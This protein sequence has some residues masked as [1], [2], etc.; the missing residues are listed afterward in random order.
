MPPIGSIWRLSNLSALR[1]ST[2]TRHRFK[3]NDSRI[4][5]KGSH[6]FVRIH[7]KSSYV[8]PGSHTSEVTPQ[9]WTYPTSRLP[10]EREALMAKN[11]HSGEVTAVPNPM[12]DTGF[13]PVSTLSVAASSSVSQVMH[14]V[15]LS[16]T[17]LPALPPVTMG[18]HSTE[19]PSYPTFLPKPSP[20]TPS[21]GSPSDP[22][23]QEIHPSQSTPSHKLSVPLIVLLAIGCSIL[24]F[25]LLSIIKCYFF[26]T[27]RPRPRPSL[28]VLD[29]P[30][31]DEKGLEDSPIFGG[32]ERVSN[33]TWSWSNYPQPE[34]VITKSPSIA[35]QDT[36]LNI[37]SQNSSLYSGLLNS[38]TLLSNHGHT[39]SVPT[40]TSGNSPFRASL[41]Q[42]QG[43]LTRSAANAS[44]KT[45]LVYPSS[46]GSQ[47]DVGLAITRSPMTSFT[48][49]GSSI[50]KRSEPKATL[51][52][53]RSESVAHAS[54]QRISYNA[55][56]SDI[57]SY[58]VSEIGS[59]SALPYTTQH[60]GTLSG[61]A[62]RS[63]IKSSYYNLNSY[64]RISNAVLPNHPRYEDSGIKA[65]SMDK[66]E[67]RRD[68]DTRGLTQ[69]LGLASPATVYLPASPQP[70][71]YPED[72][73]SVVDGKR[74][75][76]PSTAKQVPEKVKKEEHRPSLPVISTAMDA[77]AALGSLMLMDFSGNTT[78]VDDSGTT[79][80]L[81]T[82]GLNKVGGVK[83]SSVARNGST[84]RNSLKNNDN[85]PSI[86][87]PELLP[88]LEQM[89]LEH[90]NP[91]GFAEYRSPTYSIFGLYGNDR[92]SGMG[93]Y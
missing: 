52:R 17:A 18:L 10:N 76:K 49:D 75:G 44:A 62:G 79:K 15:P 91:E 70:T 27:R 40:V 3:D 38:R 45:S 35:R 5:S 90:A 31:A 12:P 37:Q 92:K 73:L 71:L 78:R 32:K 53:S 57:S 63:R 8:P 88:S 1:H 84:R 25:G 54:R 59:P 9:S 33:G 80:R 65:E 72:S 11:K 67:P 58:S 21:H 36:E 51:A 19:T 77:S 26:P 30:F 74:Y 48:G 14:S 6:R 60:Q 81:S 55:R 93:G 86:P 16:Q 23:M 29:D 20:T 61:N 41:Q 2:S 39:Q 56:H 47:T 42:I 7:H 89:G 68:R 69:A 66:T 13:R 83:G 64:P 34:I 4:Q 46:P 43:A 85:P 82:T 28:P 50:L 22:Q 24:V 87:L